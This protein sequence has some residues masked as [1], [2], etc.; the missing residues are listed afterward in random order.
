MCWGI[1]G[2]AGRHWEK[3]GGTGMC[4]DILGRA[5]GTGRN[6]EA[7]GCAGGTRR[8][9]GAPG[10]T[11]GTGMCWGHWGVWWVWGCQ[12]RGCR[13]AAGSPQPCRAPPGRG[14]STA[15]RLA[16]SVQSMASRERAAASR[17]R[18]DKSRPSTAAAVPTDI[19]PGRLSETQWLALLAAE[20]GDR[21][22]GDVLAELLGRVLE[23]CFHVYLARQVGS[24]APPAGRRG[25]RPRGPLARWPRGRGLP[26]VA[27]RAPV[28]AALCHRTG[29]RGGSCARS[30]CPSP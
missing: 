1:L 17:L 27:V 23:E 5:G 30:A 20:E 21:D 2:S 25:R 24:P 6:W 7:P 9:W 10:C 28:P 19:V 12:P 16:V 3:L 4:W 29:H 13:A 11:G 14:G 15:T 8:G 22:V 18:G 26:G